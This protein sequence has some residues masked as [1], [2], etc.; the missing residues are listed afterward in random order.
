MK[1]EEVFSR[2]G[3][4]TEKGFLRKKRA[5]GAMNVN[6]GNAEYAKASLECNYIFYKES[7]LK[8]YWS[9][10]Q[11]LSTKEQKRFLTTHHADL[12]KSINKYVDKIN[13]INVS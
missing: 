3:K 10:F 12:T 6:R 11:K 2:L 1:I 9:D 7:T 8:V 13:N 4:V 5:I